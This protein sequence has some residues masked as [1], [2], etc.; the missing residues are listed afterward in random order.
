VDFSGNGR[1]P[2]NSIMSSLLRFSF[3]NRRSATYVS[4]E[5]FIRTK[6]KKK[7]S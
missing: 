6:I 1:G 4:A 3:F 5:E 7:T 2:S